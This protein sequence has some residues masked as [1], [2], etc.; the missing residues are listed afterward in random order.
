MRLADGVLSKNFLL[1]HVIIIV[2]NLS[3]IVFEKHMDL[4]FKKNFK[5][6]DELYFNV[7]KQIIVMKKSVV[8]L[9]LMQV[10]F[11]FL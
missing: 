10:K 5:I 7:V 3:W 2:K 6:V 4:V 11:I 9:L 8:H 1:K